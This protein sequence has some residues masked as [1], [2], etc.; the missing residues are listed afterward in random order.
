MILGRIFD[1]WTNV[2]FFWTITI[3]SALDLW[4]LDDDQEDQW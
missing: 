2:K 4:G 3:D 1:W